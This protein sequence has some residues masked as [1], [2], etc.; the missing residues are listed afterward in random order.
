ML[1]VHVVCLLDDWGREMAVKQSLPSKFYL[2]LYAEN[3][4]K[5]L[6]TPF[7]QVQHSAMMSEVFM[8]QS[9]NQK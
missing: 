7:W 6:E 2:I 4:N 3:K 8:S 1:L 9:L 5:L